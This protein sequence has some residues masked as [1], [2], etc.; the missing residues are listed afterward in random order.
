MQ[1]LKPCL[2]LSQ[3]VSS[4]MLPYHESRI[5][6]ANGINCARSLAARLPPASPFRR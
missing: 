5:R 6:G 3:S 2:L 4:L 1:G